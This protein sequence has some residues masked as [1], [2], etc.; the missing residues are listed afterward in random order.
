[1]SRED[2][3]PAFPEVRIRKERDAIG[4]R[5]IKVHYG[6]MSLRE[7]YV[8][9]ALT[10]IASTI[11]HMDPA[12]IERAGESEVYAKMALVAGSLADAAIALQGED[13]G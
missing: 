4:S 6:G 5:T 13:D 3:G 12:E 1:M 10:G 8:G 7:Y 9:Q 2:G 11:S